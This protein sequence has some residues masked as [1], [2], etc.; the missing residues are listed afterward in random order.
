M[1]VF[2][3]KTRFNSTQNSISETLFPKGLSG[4][5]PEWQEVKVDLWTPPPGLHHPV[6]RISHPAQITVLG[7]HF[8]TGDP[9]LTVTLSPNPSPGPNPNRVD[10]QS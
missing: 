5:S 4:A 1:L 2:G 9:N 7:G 10:G 3:V 8:T 6:I